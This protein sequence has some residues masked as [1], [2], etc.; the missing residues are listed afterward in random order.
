[1]DVKVNI[2][3]VLRVPDGAGVTTHPED[4]LPCW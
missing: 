1:M 3:A 2:E 4:E